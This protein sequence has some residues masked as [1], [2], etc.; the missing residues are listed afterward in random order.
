M[1]T[2]GE[3]FDAVDGIF[4][5]DAAARYYAVHNAVDS[6]SPVWVSDVYV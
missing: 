2:S 5:V 4:S 6:L 1:I 3:R